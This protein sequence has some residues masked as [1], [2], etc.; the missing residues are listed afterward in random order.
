MKISKTDLKLQRKE[1]LFQA[2]L[3]AIRGDLQALMSKKDTLHPAEQEV[4]KGYRFDKRRSSYL[5]G[6]LAAKEAVMQLSNMTQP[7]TIWVDSG[8]F[9]FPIVKCPTLNNVA[10]SIS[11]CDDIG[12]CLAF[13]EAHPMGLD[14]EHI[15]AGQTEAILT[16]TA[17]S[18][19]TLLKEHALDNIQ[20][21]TAIWSIKEALSKI[22]KTGMMLDFKIIKIK[23]LAVHGPILETTFEYF[24]Q[25][26]AYS[27]I[28][29]DK[30]V[31][32]LALPGRT[33]VNLEGLWEM[34]REII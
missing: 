20:G 25:Y 26:K 17:A 19:L 27:Y 2:S 1:G 8:I 22:L 18:E 32:S 24:G 4:L 5:L 6:R 10:V 34:L 15:D 11:H 29:N 7:E 9:S 21:Y 3:A 12:L 28:R 30:Y 16:Q 31:I 14:I 33:E 13:P 23:T